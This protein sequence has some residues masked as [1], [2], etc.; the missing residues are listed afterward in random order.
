MD[1]LHKEKSRI[2]TARV[3]AGCL[4]ARPGVLRLIAEARAAGIYLACATPSQR[5][6]VVTL[7]RSLLGGEKAETIFSVLGCGDNVSRKKPAPDV[8]LW[9]LDQL[10]LQPKNCLVIEDT[11]LGFHSATTARLAT[12]MTLSTY[13]DVVTES[14]QSLSEAIAVLNHLGEIHEPFTLLAGRAYNTYTN[15]FNS[16]VDIA[17]LK[18][19]L[20]LYSHI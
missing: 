5:S 9:V 18:K 8:Y 13:S 2:Y 11:L 17:L 14:Q 12:I 6:S 7:L 10:D 4:K 19:W 15:G 3:T 16:V 20:S 1:D